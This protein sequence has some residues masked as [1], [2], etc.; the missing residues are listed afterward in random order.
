MTTAA[1]SVRERGRTKASVSK[2]SLPKQRLRLWLRLLRVSRGMESELRE[3][4]RVNYDNMTL[5]QFDV[6]A[7]LARREA[8][9]T[10]TELSR[11]LMVSN[12][13]VTGIVERLVA[14][15]LIERSAVPGDRRATIVRLTSDGQGRFAEMAAEHEG[16][17]S[18]LLGDFDRAETGHLIGQLDGLVTRL[19][20]DGAVKRSSA[21]ARTTTASNSGRTP[22][23]KSNGGSR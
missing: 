9:V 8:G 2:A 4:L 15:G 12:G 7:A 11:Y 13:N 6:L 3:R 20:D 17:V 5:P 10:M 23:P 22:K 19:R 18:E 21:T 16:W 14:D 1:P